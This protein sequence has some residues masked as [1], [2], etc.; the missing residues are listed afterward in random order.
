MTQR[1][2]RDYLEKLCL[3]GARGPL[4]N[5]QLHA[6]LWEPLPGCTL[7]TSG[8]W[9]SA[10]LPTETAAVGPAR[11]S[12]RLLV[13]PPALSPWQE[14]EE[15]LPDG[16]QRV[17]DARL[18]HAERARRARLR[19]RPG[20]CP[21][22]PVAYAGL[23][24]LLQALALFELSPRT[25]L[26]DLFAE[27]GWVLASRLAGSSGPAGGD[28]ALELEWAKAVFFTAADQ[29]AAFRA[30][31]DRVH[32]PTS[33]YWVGR[34]GDGDGGAAT[35]AEAQATLCLEDLLHAA[36][37]SWWDKSVH[38]LL[39][40]AGQ[41]HLPFLGLT[42]HSQCLA[43]YRHAADCFQADVLDVD[44]ALRVERLEGALLRAV[45]G[46]REAG[47]RVAGM[48]AF[49]MLHEAVRAQQSTAE[50]LKRRLRPTL[51]DLAA[52]LLAAGDPWPAAG[53]G[54]A[55]TEVAGRGPA[56]VCGGCPA[57]ACRCAPRLAELLWRGR[58]PRPDPAL[59]R[60]TFP[61][62]F[63]RS[64]GAGWPPVLSVCRAEGPPEE[65]PRGAA[66]AEDL[67]E[68][69]TLVDD[70]AAAMRQTLV[71]RGVA[72]WDANTGSVLAAEA[73]LRDSLDGDV[74]LFGSLAWWARDG[75][76]PGPPGVRAQCLSL[77]PPAVVALGVGEG[78]KEWVGRTLGPPLARLRALWAR[79]AG[80]LQ[81]Q[82]ARAAW[83]RFQVAGL[84]QLHRLLRPAADPVDQQLSAYLGL[85]A[86]AEAAFGAHWACWADGPRA[87]ERPSP[88]ADP[89][90]LC[91]RWAVRW[92]ALPGQGGGPPQPSSACLEVARALL[93]EPGP[94]RDAWGCAS[95]R[96]PAAYA[97]RGQ[98]ALLA[99]Q[100]VMG[101]LEAQ[102]EHWFQR[103]RT[104][105]TVVGVPAWAA[106]NWAAARA[107]LR[108]GEPCS[109]EAF[110]HF[111]LAQACG[112]G[113]AATLVA[114]INAM[115]SLRAPQ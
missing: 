105:P 78:G 114:Q 106:E 112:Q 82:H 15:D 103:T 45:A 13:L 30:A 54:P 89:W 52:F 10:L 53:A 66:P 41:A 24:Q 91:Q 59:G 36:R 3:E 37:N 62:P 98:P 88:G 6:R 93:A 27:P 58:A 73:W 14:W 83:V 72:L 92:A 99:H 68:Q 19:G 94:V 7:R 81:G 70:L 39:V 85:R 56:P 31:L 107:F 25:P 104:I 109:A 64:V 8:Q 115:P 32:G 20:T 47:K 46:A 21:V 67:A 60:R 102:I 50:L 44:R 100:E 9:P 108:T 35:W 96:G 4:T 84:M 1:E 97:V 95:L 5:F 113:F 75:P 111:L 23:R 48:W 16:D 61:D 18:H 51:P 26:Q 101:R 29:W 17:Q 33:R 40:L 34:V 71:G 63:P 76:E 69:L 42:H 74:S 49:R 11:A 90:Q 28:A 2:G 86:G 65:E 77:F 12:Q 79:V 110:L 38:R 22:C 55:P 87:G 43:T 57:G 80:S